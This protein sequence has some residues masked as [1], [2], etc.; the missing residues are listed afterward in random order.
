MKIPFYH[1]FHGNNETTYITECLKSSLATG[2]NFSRQALGALKQSLLQE[3]LLLVPSC[4]S[5]LELSLA[6]LPLQPQ[7]EVILPAFNF[8]SAANAILQKGAKPVFCDIDPQTQNI[9]ATE[10]E[11]HL[12]EKTRAVITVDYAGIACDYDTI[13]QLTADKQLFLVQDAA[14]SLGSFYKD[15]PLGVQGDFSSISF[16]HTKNIVCGEGGLFFCKNNDFFEAAK[17]YQMHGTNRQAFLD[18]LCDRYTWRQAGTSFPLNELS[19]AFLLSQLE[20]TD[21]ITNYRKSRL[22]TYLTLLKPF[23]AMGL[24]VQMQIPEYCT[25]NGHLYYLRFANHALMEEAR[26]F[27]QKNGIDA[28]T[29][30]VPLHASPMGKQLGYEPKDCPESITA[31]ETLLRLPIH[32][33]LTQAEQEMICELL[34]DWGKTKC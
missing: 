20:A 24:A 16:H 14:Q 19:C 18:G 4:S 34:L 29:H 21:T 1:R 6:L 28:R 7:D 17:I 33:G 8:P 32:T 5:G 26:L 27:L 15:K 31:Y 3:N 12:T 23:E 11:K 30:Y 10:I 9:T 22:M 13:R 2:G 25:P